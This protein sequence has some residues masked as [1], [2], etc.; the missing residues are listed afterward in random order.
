[1]IPALCLLWDCP[2]C[3]SLK[4]KKNHPLPRH[5]I[6]T[7]EPFFFSLGRFSVKYGSKNSKHSLVTYS[8]SE[9]STSKKLVFNFSLQNDFLKNPMAK[10]TFWKWNVHTD[11]GEESPATVL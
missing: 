3:K 1:M 4:K 7:K 8:F 5:T 2:D 9:T 11:F 6:K 10:G